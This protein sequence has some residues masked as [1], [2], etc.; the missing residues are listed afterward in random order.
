MEH[1]MV[2]ICLVTGLLAMGNAFADGKFAFAVIG[3]M[4]YDQKD[5]TAAYQRLIADINSD[6]EVE[7][8][9]HIGDIKAGNTPCSDDIYSQNLNHFSSFNRGLIFT[10]GDN[11][12]TDCHRE[13]NGE[14]MDPI[15]RLELIRTTFFSDNQSLG[16]Q[17]IPLTKQEGF[18]ENSRWR[19]DSVLFVT[20]NQPG[21]NNH[22]Q[23]QYNGFTEKEYKD[24][25]AANMAWLD[26]TFKVFSQDNTIKG[27]AI[28]SQANPFERYLEP[29]SD[30]NKIYYSE[31]GYADFINKLRTITK[32][33]QKRVVYFGGDTHYMR[34]DQP[35]TDIYPGC[36]ND[37]SCCIPIDVPA[38]STD[39][40]NNFTRVEVFGDKDIHWIKVDVSDTDPG[41]FKF[42]PRR[43]PGN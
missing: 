15:K 25:N 23:Q 38:K 9:A 43:V 24:R 6:I 4:P 19:K 16:Q 28:F 10:P 37:T 36:K 27:M 22:H 26:E 42:T 1:N 8:T 17:K 18:R 41:V 11:E 33:S 29:V 39:R 20:L 40:I 13:E 12:W 14:K 34:I 3:D 21:S 32:V 2:R 35:M 5:L 31:S 7:F 30:S